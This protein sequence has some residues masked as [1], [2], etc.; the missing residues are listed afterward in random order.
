[1]KKR[2]KQIITLMICL[3][4]FFLNTNYVHA[5][6]LKNNVKVYAD[7][8]DGRVVYNMD[9]YISLLNNNKV[10]PFAPTISTGE[11]ETLN[12]LQEEIVSPLDV[13]EPS[14]KCSNIFGHKWNDW[15]SWEEVSRIHFPNT[16][17]CV[18]MERWRFCAREHCSAY[19]IETDYVWVECNH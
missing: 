10:Q 2:I 9:K 13:S 11:L 17:C 7:T 12:D 1:M 15:G 16:K 14:S 19:Q 4:I 8:E 5:N 6:E 18:K 3:P